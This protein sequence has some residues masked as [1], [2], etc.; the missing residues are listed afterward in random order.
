MIEES[1]PTSRATRSRPRW[2]L[3]VGTGL[4][5]LILVSTLVWAATGRAAR[6]TSARIGSAAPE[7][8]LQQLI[9]GTPGPEAKLSSLTGHPVVVNFWATWCAPCRAE[10][11]AFESKYR[12]Y[13]DSQ[14]LIIVGIDAESDAGPAAAQQFV[15]ELGATFPIWLDSNGTAEVAYHV[16]ALPTTIV[17][18]RAGVIQDMVVG[19]PM[20]V[21]YLE[22]ELKRIF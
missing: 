11:P 4:L 20:T 14:Q 22:K 8:A 6:P 10:F 2:P 18:D 7:I 16:D 5:F 12:Q 15:D 1:A 21:D 13:K 17:I 9:N 3:W 19:G